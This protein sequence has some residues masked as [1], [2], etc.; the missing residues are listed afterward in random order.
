MRRKIYTVSLV[1][2]S[3]LLAPQTHAVED[4][5]AA[6]N[7]KTLDLSDEETAGGC[8]AHVKEK[9]CPRYRDIQIW[10]ERLRQQQEQ[11]RQEKSMQPLNIPRSK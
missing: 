10:K 7:C 8:P 3:L 11:R 5:P 2:I 9:T 4:N 1:L 6:C